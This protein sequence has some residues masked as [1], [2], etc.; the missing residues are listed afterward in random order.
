AENDIRLVRLYPRDHNYSLSGPD[1]ADL[2]TMLAERRTIT[3]LDLEQSS[4]EEIDRV[5]AAYPSLPLVVCH[6]GYR[7]LRRFAGVLDRRPNVHVDLSYLGSHQGLEW[8]VNR[9]RAAQVLF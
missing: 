6:L 7:G 2:L 4:W 9:G 3:V 8:L 5:A 1:A